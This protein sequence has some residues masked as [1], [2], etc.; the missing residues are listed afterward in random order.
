MN[1]KWE[2]ISLS[3]LL[4]L[5]E[6]ETDRLSASQRDY[7]ELIKVCPEVMPLHRPNKFCEDAYVLAKHEGFVIFYDDI[8]EDFAVARCQGLAKKMTI[9]CLFMDFSAALMYVSEHVSGK[10]PDS[11]PDSH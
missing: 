7:F 6:E 8:E 3:E 4:R 9:D 11:K 5:M 10:D 1:E 2:P